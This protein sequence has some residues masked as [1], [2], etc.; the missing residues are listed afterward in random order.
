MAENSVIPLFMSPA[1][2]SRQ[3]VNRQYAD[4][5]LH[6][7]G[8]FD[9]TRRTTSASGERMKAGRSIAPSV[10]DVFSAAAWPRR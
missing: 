4:W 10:A 1:V 6:K 3:K 8:V 7:I 9:T 5:I 2:V